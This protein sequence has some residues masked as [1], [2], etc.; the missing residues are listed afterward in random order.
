MQVG[1]YCER[2]SATEQ[3]NGSSEVEGWGTYVLKE[4]LKVLKAEI[5]RWCKE[6]IGRVEARIIELKNTIAGFDK[7]A[8]DQVLSDED[9]RL[10]LEAT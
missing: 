8:E 2:N 3:T 4:K 7:K 1:G 10:R 9:V 5:K 6:N